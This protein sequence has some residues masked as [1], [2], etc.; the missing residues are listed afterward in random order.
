MSNLLAFLVL[1]FGIFLFSFTLWKNLREDYQDESIFDFT[2]WVLL[3]VVLGRFIFFKV[4]PEAFWQG[5]FI[6]NWGEVGGTAVV[7][8]LA[9]KKLEFRF[10]ELLEAL[11]PSF[12]YLVLSVL[13]FSLLRAGTLFEFQLPDLVEIAAAVLSLLIFYFFHQRYRRLS[14]YPSG[15]IGLGS[16]VAAAFYFTFRAIAFLLLPMLSFE[17]KV[18]YSLPAVILGAVFALT[19]AKRSENERLSKALKKR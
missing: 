14:W 17:Q 19:L 1:L 3:G 11:T 9:L 2:V 15:K 13:L 18:F 16:L 4:I 12:F 8:L 7:V 6:L 5:S 10:F